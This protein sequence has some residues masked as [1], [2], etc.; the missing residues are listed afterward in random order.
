MKKLDKIRKII[1]AVIFIFALGMGILYAL[2]LKVQKVSSNAEDG[3]LLI[4][5]KEGGFYSDS[6]EVGLETDLEAEIYYTLDGS[7]P[8]PGNPKACKYE[9]KIELQAGEAEYAC[10]LRAAVFKDNVMLSEV[11]SRTYLI[12]ADIKERYTIP[13]LAV[14]GTPEDF[15]NYEDGILVRGKLDDEFMAQHP[16]WMDLLEANM[17]Q[18]PGNVYQSGRE[19]E[20]EVFVTLFDEEG[21][22]IFAQ[23][24][25]FR[26]YGAASR[27]KNQPSFRLYAR[28]EYDE[29]NDFDYLFFDDQYTSQNA[30]QSDFKRVI[31]RNGG[32]DNGYAFIRSELATRIAKQAG[33]RDTP[34]AS[35]VCVYLN[36]E[37][38]GVHWF[39]TNFDD[40]YFRQ[41]YGEYTGR[42]YIFEGE[43][44]EVL[45]QEEDGDS[46]YV[47]LA[48]QYNSIISHFEELDLNNEE[49]WQALN[50]AVDVENYIK[51]CA[52]QHYICNDDSLMNNFRVY[53]YYAK[54][55]KYTPGTVFDGRYHFL[56]FDLDKG[57]GL[58]QKESE[59]N[60]VAYK[61]TAERIIGE[62]GYDEIFA[63]ILQRKDCREL[64][65]QYTLSLMNYYYSLD[66]LSKV[67]DE[68]HTERD[69]EL[70]YMVEN[71]DLLVNNFYAP[72][73]TDYDYVQEQVLQ[74]KAF[75]L[76]RP[77]IAMQD[78]QDAFGGMTPYTLQLSNPNEACIMVDYAVLCEKEYTGT[79]FEQVPVQIS[80]QPKAGYE[81]VHWL[82]NGEVVEA[83]SFTV[84]VSQI[85]NGEVTIVCVCEAK[86]TADLCISGVKAKGGDFIEI[87]N[88][89][90]E[91][92]N[93]GSYCLSDEKFEEK[94]TLPKSIVMPGE[95]IRIY[96]ENYTE[97]EALGQPGVN[98]SIKVG[99]TISLYYADG[100]L[101]DSIEVSA[102]GSDRGVWQKDMYTGALKEVLVE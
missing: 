19:A 26:V 5:S 18:I 43:M 46:V 93:L 23:N 92:K 51:Y 35:P 89:S 36:G 86:E 50:A 47:E 7:R 13:V 84:E 98:F 69:A 41:S 72:D 54:D 38:Y 6:F 15:Y 73:V 94:S 22:R 24:C 20:K 52:L 56:L 21:N 27:M 88:L 30:L 75:A 10:T 29:D 34:S 65:I 85:L 32:N 14:S 95:T 33:F 9:E 11:E 48:E 45:L 96:C 59:Q 78:L 81:F 55:G 8:A 28:S 67:L 82:V 71:T 2:F 17:I 12:G 64:Y 63:Q 1:I 60:P 3:R 40:D 102:L 25:G 74:I 57:L 62:D 37:Y 77:E 79:Y 83:G 31:V 100:S 70:R 58:M 80:A 39:V 49:G 87:T 44:D 4:F 101:V 66:Y 53:R 61:L 16:E 68:M 97:S 42:M 99:E 76:Q 91:T 90:E